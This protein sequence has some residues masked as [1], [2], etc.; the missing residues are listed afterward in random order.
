VANDTTIKARWLEGQRGLFARQ[1]HVVLNLDALNKL[2]ELLEI[3]ESY[4][5][6]RRYVGPVDPARPGLHRLAYD[7]ALTVGI[8]GGY[9]TI[10]E[11]G[12][13]RKWELNGSGSDA[14]FA[15]LDEIRANGDLPNPLQG[16]LFDPALWNR[17]EPT[18]LRHGIPYPGFRLAVY[19]E[20]GTLRAVGITRDIIDQ[21]RT[22][23]R[24]DFDLGDVVAL[25]EQLPTAYGRDIFYKKAALYFVFLSLA[26][27]ELGFKVNADI[28]APS[29]YRQEQ[30]FRMFGLI[31]LADPLRQTICSGLPLDEES[32]ELIALRLANILLVEELANRTG[33]SIVRLDTALFA[34]TKTE[35]HKRLASVHPHFI[36][37]KKQL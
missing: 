10:D 19:E 29:E 18:L 20:L 22:G 30:T 8:I 34:M 3:P 25:S 7:M 23:D 9:M 21:C 36:T 28:I 33:E 35:W 13:P 26:L 32:E 1:T 24:F 12:R 15:L 31:R 37:T 14:T 27:T 11:H 5:H 2:V 17:V 16:R 4:S 6:W